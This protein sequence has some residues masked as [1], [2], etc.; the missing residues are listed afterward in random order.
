MQLSTQCGHKDIKVR[1][2][3][4]FWKNLFRI[5]T[6]FVLF[7][8]CTN[9]VL[10]NN[11]EKECFNKLLSEYELLSGDEFYKL[12]H[13][14]SQECDK[15]HIMFKYDEVLASIGVKNI[16][17]AKKKLKSI[18]NN[19]SLKER[20]VY[21]EL[22]TFI[23]LEM[24]YM[25]AINNNKF[26]QAT[27]EEIEQL[28]LEL[29]SLDSSPDS[30]VFQLVQA[31]IYIGKINDTKPYIEY[32]LE[33]ANELNDTEKSQLYSLMSMVSYF[34]G[35]FEYSIKYAQDAQKYADIYSSVD[36]ISILAAALVEL[37]KV[38]EAAQLLNKLID[39]S[40]SPQL[41]PYFVQS[42]NLVKDKANKKAQTETINNKD[43]FYSQNG[44]K[45]RRKFIALYSLDNIDTIYSSYVNIWLNQVESA[46]ANEF[47]KRGLNGELVIDVALN[48]NGSINEITIRRSSG[49]ETID[50]AA[51]KVVELAAPYKPFSDLMKKETDILHLTGKFQFF[52]E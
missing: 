11:S 52:S 45:P 4:S 7:I 41:H 42:Y 3:N 26:D 14:P 48:T 9:F 5:F 10:A 47:E 2:S 35:K 49:K 28:A 23:R 34:K 16:E 24:A 43:N 37:D 40:D 29:Y 51:I 18:K 30:H 44:R 33:H 32:L 1:N 31:Q 25:E 50:D 15:N 6:L 12:I 19:F 8:F 36:T 27:W 20:S 21:Q 22:D 39:N 17:D 38:D 46:F 13:S